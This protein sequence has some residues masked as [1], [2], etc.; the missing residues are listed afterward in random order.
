MLGALRPLMTAAAADPATSP[1]KP[2]D[3]ESA[4]FAPDPC[5]TPAQLVA[6]LERAWKVG[7]A[8][9]IASLCDSATARVGVTPGAPPAAAPTMKA[10]GFLLHDQ[11]QLVAT[12]RFHVVW[13]EVDAKKRTARARARWLGDFGGTRG[14]REIEVML[15]AHAVGDGWLLTEI[16]AND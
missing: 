3:S 12:R 8:S 15:A 5:A 16:R 10:I 9:A 1:P 13:L 2:V 7:D 14:T 4:S 11:L 6:A